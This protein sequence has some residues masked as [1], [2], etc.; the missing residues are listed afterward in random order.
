MAAPGRD[1]RSPD[2]PSGLT[3]A[4]AL[5]G[6]GLDR[7]DAELLLADVLGRSRTWLFAHPDAAL[8]EREKGRFEALL[9]QRRQGVP[10]AHL[11]GRKA[12]WN[13]N[14]RVSPDTLIPRP[15]TEL[16]VELALDAIPAAAPARVLDLGTG[17]GAIALAIASERPQ[18]WILAT[19]RDPGAIQLARRNARLHRLDNVRF[20]CGDWFD[21][22]RPTGFDLVVSNP[23]YLAADDPHLERGDLRFEPRSA[24]VA[25]EAGLADLRRLAEQSARYLRPGGTLI[26]EHGW[27]QQ[28]SVLALLVHNASFEPSG[29]RDLAGRPRAVA[30]RLR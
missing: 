6:A 25:A 29:H 30:A 21:P 22:L 23:P 1:H 7:L 17:T 19:D 13:Q 3:V 8:P 10:V 18:A 26:V 15:E 16:L 9:A 4:E 27:N 28:E 12:F 11:V 2:G 14:L 5:A 24:L 20:L